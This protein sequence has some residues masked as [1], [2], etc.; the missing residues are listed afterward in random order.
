MN[1][2]QVKSYPVF[3]VL[4]GIVSLSLYAS[5]PISVRLSDTASVQLTIPDDW[6]A[7]KHV[8][9]A[10]VE[11]RLVPREKGDFM[12]LMTILPLPADSPLSSPAALKKTIQERG[13][14]ELPGALQEHLELTELKTASSVGY[15]YHLT[16][17]NPEKGPGDYREATQ[18]GILGSN[19]LV[20]ITILTHSG[21]EA[22]V[23]RA[24]E[25]LKTLR[26]VSAD[27][28]APPT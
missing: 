2:M 7:Q 21:D 10:S 11:V 17:R 9:S 3:F 13:S 19:H 28:A 8:G 14:G 20:S 4:T 27:P 6:K 23:M 18:G 26:I 5:Q 15:F 24:M 25:A 1:S 22:I 12:I 16:D